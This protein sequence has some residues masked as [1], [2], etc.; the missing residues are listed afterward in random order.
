MQILGEGFRKA[1]LE[2]DYEKALSLRG[3]DFQR[4]LLQ[5]VRV[6]SR[7]ARGNYDTLLTGLRQALEARNERR[8]LLEAAGGT[9]TSVPCSSVATI[10]KAIIQRLECCFVA[11]IRVLPWKAK[12]KKKTELLNK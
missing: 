9:L 5:V 12:E 2:E 1:T 3:E 8:K 10:N 11:A 4:F 7:K 6:E